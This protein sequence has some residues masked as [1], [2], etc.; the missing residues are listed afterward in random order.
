M[1]LMIQGLMGYDRYN[2]EYKKFL[3][4][5][6]FFFRPIDIYLFSIKK[7]KMVKKTK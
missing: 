5:N 6:E 1:V 2:I 7:I 4:N 3:H